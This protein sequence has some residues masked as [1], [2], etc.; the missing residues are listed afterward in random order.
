MKWIQRFMLLSVLVVCFQNC[1]GAQSTQ[2]GGNGSLASVSEKANFTW[3]NENLVK[4]K[5][6]E[7]HNYSLAFSGLNFTTY[8]GVLEALTPGSPDDS[9]FYVRSFT[10]TFFT[11]TDEER[12]VIRLWILNGAEN[13]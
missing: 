8:D 9:P 10:T 7:C 3:I 11:L 2:S 13:N 12:E 5:C 4:E 6:V 1:G